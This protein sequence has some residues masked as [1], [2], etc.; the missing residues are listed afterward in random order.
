MVVSGEW[1][2]GYGNKLDQAASRSLTQGAFYS[3]P[4]DVAHFAFTEDQPAVVYITGVG[5][6]DTHFVE[7]KDIR[8][9]P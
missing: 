2:F 6:S 4:A 9:K 3:E 7:E 8:P 5:P 1:H